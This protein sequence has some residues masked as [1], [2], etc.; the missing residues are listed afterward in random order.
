MNDILEE[1]DA[2][3]FKVMYVICSVLLAARRWA[4]NIFAFVHMRVYVCLSFVLAT[5]VMNHWTEL[6]EI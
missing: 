2:G 1:P 5:T 3:V 4:E 6:F